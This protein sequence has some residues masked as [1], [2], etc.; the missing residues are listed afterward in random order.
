MNPNQ[1]NPTG[2]IVTC[3][4]ILYI[5]SLFFAVEYSAY[6]A[7]YPTCSTSTVI[8]FMFEQMPENNFFLPTE[9]KDVG[10]IIGI[11]TAA[12]GLVTWWI[13][14]EA[15]ANEHAAFGKEYGSA[16]FL[17]D[18]YKY[19]LKFADVEALYSE[20]GIHVPLQYRWKQFISSLKKGKK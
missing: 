19:S 8:S 18:T 10:A 11:L 20:P 6:A 9:P 7:L 17:K 3:A 12:F 16:K 5:I 2:P 13:L 14:A 15:K 4:V 1:K